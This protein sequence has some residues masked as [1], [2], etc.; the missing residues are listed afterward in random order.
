MA[1]VAHPPVAPSEQRLV[2]HDISW[3]TYER[4]VADHIDRRVPRFTYNRG[5]LEIVSPGTKHERDSVSVTLLVEIVAGAH[6]LPV[7][8]VGSMTYKRRTAER[9][10]E[11]DASF[12]VRSEPLVRNKDQIDAEEDPPPDLVVEVD[13]ANPSLDKLLVFAGLG[14]PEVWRWADNRLRIY[15]LEADVY[16][17]TDRSAALPMLT[18][19]I[20]TRFMAESRSVPRPVWLQTLTA[21]AERTSAAGEGSIRRP[22]PTSDR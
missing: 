8:S 1:T 13:V 22:T 16:R 10:F 15:L 18:A 6:A 5:E 20:V 14:V 9:G 17:E 19:R 3:G 12:Y 21:W 7:L 11:P 4:I 2:L